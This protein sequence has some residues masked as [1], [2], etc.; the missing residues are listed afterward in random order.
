MVGIDL[1]YMLVSMYKTPMRS[2]RWYLPIFGYILD[3]ARANSWLLYKR[4]SKILNHKIISLKIFLYDIAT[5]LL[6]LNKKVQVGRPLYTLRRRELRK[7]HHLLMC[8][9]T[10][11]TIGHY[12][13]DQTASLEEDVLFAQRVCWV[14]NVQ[15]VMYSCA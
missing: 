15:N 4:V 8:V 11:S 5:T 3:C 10:A 7:K 14:S 9:T 13:W 6:K 2:P 12:L 1:S